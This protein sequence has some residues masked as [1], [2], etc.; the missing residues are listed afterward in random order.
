MFLHPSMK[1]GAQSKIQYFFYDPVKN[2]RMEYQYHNRIVNAGK[3]HVLKF[4]NKRS[5]SYVRMILERELN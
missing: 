2:A 1:S 5:A 4:T 3:P